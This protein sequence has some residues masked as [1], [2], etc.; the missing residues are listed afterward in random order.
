M[1][2]SMIDLARANA[3]KA[4]HRNA[5]FHLSTI[6]KLPLP[7]NSVDC[8][9]SNCVLNLAPDKA[10]VFREMFRVLKPGGR[11]QSAT[12][13]S[14]NRCRTNWPAMCWPTSAASPEPF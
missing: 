9:I 10:S 12:S 5:D 13:P 3:A 1:T 11:W 8:L 2:P 14:R 6:D 4:G 7:D